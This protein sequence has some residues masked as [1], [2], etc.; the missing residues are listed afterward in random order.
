MDSLEIDPGHS[1]Y[2]SVEI[3][4]GFHASDR[5]YV[6]PRE[7]GA[8]SRDH[9]IPQI[10]PD[11]R[12]NRES[13]DEWVVLC[14]TANRRVTLLFGECLY[15]FH[16]LLDPLL[17]FVTSPESRLVDVHPSLHRPP[18]EVELTGMRPH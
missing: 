7:F 14:Q 2:S 18:G 8:T 15:E 10:P 3:W 6:P 4:R 13:V 5:T 1:A 9:A 17:E 12:R 11:A 16:T